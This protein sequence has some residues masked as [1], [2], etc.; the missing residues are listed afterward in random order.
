MLTL[1]WEGIE[2]TLSHTEPAYS[3]PWHHLEVKAT[4]RLP[5]TET[6]YKSHFIHPKEL[7]F[8]ESPEAFLL[9][10]LNET[11]KDPSWRVYRQ[12]SRQLSLF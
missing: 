4:E 3:A 1:Y 7:A 10:W 6:G 12:Q 2:V 8:W 11:A 5:I 9:D